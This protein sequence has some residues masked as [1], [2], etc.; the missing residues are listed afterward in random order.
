LDDRWFPKTWDSGIFS[1]LLNSYIF[2]PL[3]IVFDQ[4]QVLISKP[5]N[6]EYEYARSYVFDSPVGGIGTSLTILL[7]SFFTHIFF[8]PKKSVF[9][10]I[11]V[12]PVILLALGLISLFS[13]STS[14]MPR[15]ALGSTLVILVFLLIFYDQNFNDLYLRLGFNS[16][17]LIS[18]F[19]NLLGN[20]EKQ[21]KPTVEI[22]KRYHNANDVLFPTLGIA[23]NNINLRELMGNCPSI[24]IEL[25][26]KEFTNWVYSD[27][28]CDKVFYYF[29]PGRMKSS[30]NEKF[31]SGD[32]I[33]MLLN[34]HLNSY[35]TG[36]F[37][38]IRSDFSILN[39]NVAPY[40]D[41]SYL[42]FPY[43][44]SV[45]KL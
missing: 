8:H 10:N 13:I 37:P 40:W 4:I 42:Y 26:R 33:I 31:K 2:S 7:L 43:V 44:Y 38:I 17:L 6:F 28:K 36:D 19:L 18:L 41:S 11:Q 12:S 45:S 27:L 29:E 30:I 24:L 32:K 35:N 16:F 39:I 21:Y 14:W 9:K 20:Y 34:S 5:I 23:N 15:Y 22:S 1:A 25:P 3:R